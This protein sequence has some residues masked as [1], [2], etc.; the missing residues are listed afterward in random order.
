MKYEFT[1]LN[2]PK[3][4]AFKDNVSKHHHNI[5]DFVS[6]SDLRAQGMSDDTIADITSEYFDPEIWPIRK[7]P[8]NKLEGAFLGAHQ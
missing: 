4:Q 1:S 5:I 2:E 3:Y 7:D 8:G 6:I